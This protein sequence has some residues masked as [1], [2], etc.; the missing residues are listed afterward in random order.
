MKLCVGLHYRLFKH[1]GE[2][3]RVQCTHRTHSLKVVGL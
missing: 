3:T 2:F 1:F